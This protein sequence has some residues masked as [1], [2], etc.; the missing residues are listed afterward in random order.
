MAKFVFP[1]TQILVR[2]TNV[3]FDA[4]VSATDPTALTAAVI[5]PANTEATDKVYTLEVV[6][7][8]KATGIVTTVTVPAVVTVPYQAAG[9]TVDQAAVTSEGG[10]ATATV[11]FTAPAVG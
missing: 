1:K 11:T 9:V 2:E 5:L 7:E 10:T 8:D 6:T 3:L 4:V